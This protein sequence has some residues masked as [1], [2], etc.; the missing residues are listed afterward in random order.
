MNTHSTSGSGSTPDELQVQHLH[1]DSDDHR[2]NALFTKLKS[3]GYRCTRYT[4]PPGTVF[5]EHSHSTDK[6]DAV[7]S[8]CL[9]ITTQN[10]QADL[11][12]GD[13][14]LIPRGLVHR[15]EVIGKE[16]VVSLDGVRK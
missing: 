2:E 12:P 14:V 8:G 7:L 4:Y 16:A 11:G 13:Y 3:L 10:D 6:I 15:A 5:P 9:R 1:T